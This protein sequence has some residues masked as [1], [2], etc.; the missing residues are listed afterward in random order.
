MLHANGYT[1]L[2]F[3]SENVDGIDHKM[4]GGNSEVT[5]EGDVVGSPPE[6]LFLKCGWIILLT[7]NR[8]VGGF[9]Q[10]FKML[11]LCWS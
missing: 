7:D 11:V 3:T 1:E 2:L 8:Y 5:W 4:D 9:A 10:F 6:N